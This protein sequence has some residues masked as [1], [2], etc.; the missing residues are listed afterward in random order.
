[1]K[2][3]FVTNDKGKKVA[4]VVPIREYNKMLKD[5]EELEDIT[6]YDQAK[7]N[8]PE[9]LPIDEAFSIIEAERKKQILCQ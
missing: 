3:Q 5:L 2:T 1:M 4:A 8:D 6:L 7:K 9:G